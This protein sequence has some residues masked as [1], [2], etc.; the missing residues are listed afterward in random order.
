VAW[1]DSEKKN[2]NTLERDP[3][4]RL[5]MDRRRKTST[6]FAWRITEVNFGAN[7]VSVLG[8]GRAVKAWCLLH[9]MGE[10]YLREAGFKAERWRL[11][12]GRVSG[13]G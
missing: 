5:E 13:G 4:S 7:G 6:E 12:S 1:G 9:R 3:C 10:G 11:G 2:K 8:E